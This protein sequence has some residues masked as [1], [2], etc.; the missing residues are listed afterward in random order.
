MHRLLGTLLAFFLIG[1]GPKKVAG[2]LRM[3][4]DGQWFVLQDE[5]HRPLNV[6]RVET[7]GEGR[8]VI[9]YAFRAHRVVTFVATPDETY[10]KAGILTG[11]SVG[12][13][14]AVVTVG[15]SAKQ[16]Q[17]PGSNVWFYGLF[18]TR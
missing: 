16:A 11:A 12:L 18:E 9:H 8:A 1:C 17:I 7:D 2:A 5:G 4:P 10:A 14:R 3:G 13:D 6:E 15:T